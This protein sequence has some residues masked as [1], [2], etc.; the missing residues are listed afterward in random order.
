[1]ISRIT[2]LL[3]TLLLIGATCREYVVTEERKEAGKAK[4][5]IAKI[6]TGIKD[7]DVRIKKAKASGNIKQLEKL[8]WEKD[9]KI[10]NLISECNDAVSALEATEF[11]LNATKKK[12]SEIA[13]DNN[14]F[15][16]I[17]V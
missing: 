1:M 10:N 4:A 7:V 17:K 2:V 11:D 9:T 6:E 12:L 16:K 8:L 5:K 14:F 15:V 13:A 3:V